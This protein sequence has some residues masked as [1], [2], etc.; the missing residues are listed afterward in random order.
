VPI[1][2]ERDDERRR[3]VIMTTGHVTGE[4]VRSTLD[5]Q[6]KEGAWSYSVLYD[7]RAGRNIP[8]IDDVRRLVL[9]VGE[10]TCRYGPRGS[11]ALVSSDPQLSKMGRAYANLGE[12]TSLDV[13]V[14][15]DVDEAERWLDEAHTAS[16]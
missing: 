10:L 15:T 12:L 14:F 13:K 6:A 1:H 2:Y 4:E 16:G 8:T 11:V 3:I 7:A 9:H 5:R